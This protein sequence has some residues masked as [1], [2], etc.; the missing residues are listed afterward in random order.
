[1]VALPAK[2]YPGAWASCPLRA[3]LKTELP[4][5]P[6][7]QALPGNACREAL[8]PLLG[9]RGR[10]WEQG[11]VSFVE[12]SALTPGPSPTLWERGGGGSLD[13]LPERPP[14]RAL[15]EGSTII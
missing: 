10:A 6:R 2:P 5:P 4:A 9:H 3:K 11:K 12:V 13:W 7:P 15:G 14:P 1:M 8:P